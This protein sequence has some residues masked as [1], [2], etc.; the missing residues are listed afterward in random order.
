MN[1]FKHPV[2]NESI[3]APSDMQ[4]GSCSD[5]PCIV[6]RDEYGMWVTSFWKPDE[7]E[8]AEIVAGGSIRLQVRCSTKNHPVV[9]VSV[10]FKPSGVKE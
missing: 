1:I 6:T 4:D 2:C 10:A 7:H 5:L 3:G 8:I 9:A